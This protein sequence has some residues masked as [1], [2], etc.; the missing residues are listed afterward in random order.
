[1]PY[2]RTIS[3]VVPTYNEVLNVLPMCEAL[4]AMMQKSLPQYAY[5]II[6][7]DN[8]STDGTRE[9][10]EALCAQHSTVRAIFNA[11]NFG[12]FNSP[13]HGIC[14]AT[15]DCVIP[16]CADF[17]DPVELIPTLVKKWE[18]GHMVVCAVKKESRENALMRLARTCYYKLMRRASVVDFI[19]HFTG[20]GLYDK[21]F[22][23]ILRELDDPT[24]FL[25]GIVAELGA[26]VAMVPYEQ[27][28]RRA[29]RTHNSFSTLYDAAM[30]S[31][32]T[33][34]AFPIRAITLLG[35]VAFFVSLLFGAFLT[36]RRINGVVFDPVWWLFSLTGA[37]FGLLAG[38]IGILGEYLL[39][40][41]GKLLRRPL[42]VEERR[43]SFEHDRE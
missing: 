37:L 28:K 13:Y 9:K 21:S 35:A 31:V 41:R 24:P 20:F 27:Q 22:V 38:A 29:G 15:G 14:A 1:M 7:I 8:D 4:I 19:E 10:I 42:V 3:V 25:R 34:T 40:L 12:Q 18:A 5:E 30:L 23:D 16:I 11:R 33:Y 36:V 17:Q 2:A 32:T 43:I 39:L 26:R 6:F